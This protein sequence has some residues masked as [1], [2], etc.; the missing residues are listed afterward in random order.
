MIFSIWFFSFW[1]Y[2]RFWIQREKEKE[3]VFDRLLGCGF[4]GDLLRCF[5]R[6]LG[7]VLFFLRHVVGLHFRDGC[8]PPKTWL[9]PPNHWSAAAL[10]CRLVLRSD[11]PDDTCDHEVLRADAAGHLLCLL[12]TFLPVKSKVIMLAWNKW[13]KKISVL[14]EHVEA[15]WAADFVIGR[16]REHSRRRSQYFC[17][18]TKLVDAFLWRSFCNQRTL[19]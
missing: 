14:G 4:L 5:F 8:M 7:D 10:P 6:Q 16:E 2:L 13:T 11:R 18:I 12:L 17:L 3:N 15:V 9:T 19:Q 1:G